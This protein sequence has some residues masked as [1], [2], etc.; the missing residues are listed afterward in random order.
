MKIT[1]VQSSFLPLFTLSL[2]ISFYGVSSYYP[3]VLVHG[4][5]NGPAE[6]NDFLKILETVSLYNY[7]CL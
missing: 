4:I 3:V 2:L 1:A 7:Y 6:F 5:L